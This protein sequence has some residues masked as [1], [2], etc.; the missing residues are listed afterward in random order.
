M[1]PDVMHVRHCM[2]YEFW[3]GK[4]A[5]EAAKSICCAYGDGTISVRTCQEWFAQFRCE[6]YDLND[7]ER[8][9][10]PQE[11][12]S[13]D[14]QALLD[15]DSSQSTRELGE[16]LGV[17]HMTIANRLHKMGK[18]QKAGKWVP[19]QLTE[20]NIGQR[21]NTCV[22]LASKFKKKRFFTQNSNRR[23]EIDIF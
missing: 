17:S 15:E 23:R 10:R 11:L 20:V 7:A 2:L 4:N 22:F 3:Q 14:L 21:L 5:T 6:N 19:R 13:D 18:I 1:N 16:C 8:S 12:H 9:G